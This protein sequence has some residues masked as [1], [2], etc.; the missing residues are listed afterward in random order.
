M[1]LQREQ[2]LLVLSFHFSWKGR[3][4]PSH[5]ALTEMTSRFVLSLVFQLDA[6][7][8][9][10][11][12]IGG[13]PCNDLSIVNPIRKGLYGTFMFSVWMWRFLAKSLFIFFFSAFALLSDRGHGQTVL[14]VLPHPP[15]AE[16]QRGRS[17]TLLL[18]LR[19]RGLHEHARQSQ[20]FPLSWGLFWNFLSFFP[21]LLLYSCVPVCLDTQHV[22]EHNDWNSLVWICK[23]S[24][25]FPQSFN[26]VSCCITKPLSPSVV[27]EGAAGGAVKPN[28]L[29]LWFSV[30]NVSKM[31]HLELKSHQLSSRSF[32]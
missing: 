27:P 25:F 21:P 12:L 23:N 5:D 13:S 16:T 1:M 26:P 10:D 14:W 15:A 30:E 11:L 32:N 2:K 3:G 22:C 20:Y 29:L 4:K 28:W 18:A 31:R 24:L 7:G 9:F 8:P 17:Q 6:G 19:E